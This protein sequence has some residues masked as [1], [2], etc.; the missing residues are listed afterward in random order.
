M[1][2]L[3]DVEVPWSSREETRKCEIGV[4]TNMDTT[5]TFDQQGINDKLFF[6]LFI[7]SEFGYN[8]P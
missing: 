5:S 4:L 7:T 8:V 1:D 2:H 6:S 3:Y